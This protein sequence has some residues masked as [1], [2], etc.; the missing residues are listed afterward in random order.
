MDFWG[1]MLVP[2][3]VDVWLSSVSS[4]L[5]INK[6]SG[7]AKNQIQESEHLLQDQPFCLA[8]KLQYKSEQ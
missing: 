8:C 1:D 2:R 3:R 7:R 5:K 6:L 4:K